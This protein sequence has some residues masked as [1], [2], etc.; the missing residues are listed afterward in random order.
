MKKKKNSESWK[1]VRTVLADRSKAELLKLVAD[2]YASSSDN[3]NFI[4]ARCAVGTIGID[5]YKKLISES[6]YPDIYNNKPI[7]LSVGKRAISDYFKATKDELG[8]LELMTHYLE[9]GNQFTVDFG[10]IDER[11]YS[12]LES[13]FKNIISLLKKQPVEVV[14]KYLVRLRE[15]VSSSENIGWGYHDSIGDLLAEYENYA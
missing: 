3:K 8:K 12:S 5:E 15:V 10:D 4:H 7:K 6:I 2:L 11:F 13:M 1:T 9:S 14:E